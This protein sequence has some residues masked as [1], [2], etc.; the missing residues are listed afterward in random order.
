[1]T[2]YLSLILL[3]IVDFSC[4]DLK[5]LVLVFVAFVRVRFVSDQLAGHFVEPEVE[6]G[7]SSYS[8]GSTAA[9]PRDCILNHY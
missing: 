6:F 7:T 5:I 8:T 1:M 9:Y 3:L 4:F 2:P